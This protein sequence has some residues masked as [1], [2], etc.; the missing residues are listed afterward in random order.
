MIGLSS[1][2]RQYFTFG[3]GITQ[4]GSWWIQL[5]HRKNNVFRSSTKP[6]MLVGAFKKEFYFPFHIYIWDNPSHWRTHIVQDGYCTTN[7]MENGPF[8]DDFPIETSI[9]WGFSMF[10]HG[11]SSAAPRK[12]P[13]T[14]CR[15]A[16]HPG[17]PPRKRATSRRWWC[18]W[19]ITDSLAER[20]PG[21]WNSRMTTGWCPSSLAKLVYK[22][23]NYGL[24]QI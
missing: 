22:S 20:A 10:L 6:S 23:H 13:G 12:N 2:R 11:H 8:I 14:V 9:F 7:Q 5:E 1:Q 18:A 3:P 15:L 4:I 21:W 17:S 24:W 16:W 19:E